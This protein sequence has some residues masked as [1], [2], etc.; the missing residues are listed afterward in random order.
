MTTVRTLVGIARP[1]AD[2]GIAEFLN[3]RPLCTS[4]AEHEAFHLELPQSK[5]SCCTAQSECCNNPRLIETEKPAARVTQRR[6]QGG[7]HKRYG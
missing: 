1:H 4:L 5:V 6:E 2:H 3:T 7:V